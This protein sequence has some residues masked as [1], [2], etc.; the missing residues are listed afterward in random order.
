MSTPQL[1]EVGLVKEVA[2][3][4]IDGGVRH[5]EEVAVGHGGGDLGDLLHHLIEEALLEGAEEG[6]FGSEVPEEASL[7]NASV[8]RY[9]R[10]GG[11]R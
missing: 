6:V 9:V 10:H 7:R 2:D 11:G 3:G 1:D 4:G 8:A 5:I